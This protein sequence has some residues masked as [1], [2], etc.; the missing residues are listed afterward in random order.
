MPDLHIASSETRLAEMAADFIEESARRAIAERGTFHFCLSGGSTPEPTY[1]LLRAPERRGRIDW[2][3]VMFYW[4]DERPVPPTHPESNYA[5][6][7]EALLDYIGVPER[8]VQRIRGELKVND[9]A[10]DYARRLVDCFGRDADWPRFDLVMLGLG[11]DGHTA[12]LF[13]GTDALGQTRRW[14]V[15]N[16]VPKLEQ[17]RLTLTYPSINHAGA[18]MFLVAGQPKAPVVRRVIEGDPSCPASKVQ[19]AKGA[20]SWFLDEAAASQLD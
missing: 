19:P 20:P 11:E 17:T 9:A 13:P 12:S 1:R 2:D 5:M 4:G 16:P 10:I 15:A 3:R 7:K 6:A 18:I 14:V 8:Q